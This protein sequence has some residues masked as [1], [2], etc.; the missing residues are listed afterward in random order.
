[1]A[2]LKEGR[3]YGEEKS[4]SIMKNQALEETFRSFCDVVIDNNGTVEETMGQIQR[5]LKLLGQASFGR[6]E[7]V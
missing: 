4:L 3:G 5:R 7:D 1:M 2:R 6:Q